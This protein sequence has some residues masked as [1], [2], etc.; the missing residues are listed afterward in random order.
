MKLRDFVGGTLGL[1]VVT[2]MLWA[3][4]LVVCAI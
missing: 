1:A 3:A 4:L 2:L